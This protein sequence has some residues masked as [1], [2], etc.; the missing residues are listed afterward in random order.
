MK[1]IGMY[2]HIP[3]CKQKCKYCDF[4]SF[5]YD[6]NKVQEYFTYLLQEI[7]EKSNEIVLQK[8][9]E[10]NQVQKIKDL[11]EINT[12]YIGGGTPSIVSEKY[13][14]QILTQIRKN[15]K[16]ADNAEI[17]IEINPGTVNEEKLKKYLQIGINRISIGLQSANDKLL[18]MLGRIHTYEEFTEVYKLAREVGFKN[19]NVDL[20]IGLPTQKQ[21]DVKNTLKN[22]IEMNPEHIS[23]YSL[24]VEEN[25]QMYDLIEQGK[26]KL[27][28]EKT[29]R[30]MYWNVKNVL[31]E[32]G[33]IHYEISNFSKENKQSKHNL[34]CWN[35]EDY[36]GFGIAA[37]S[38]FNGIRYSNID[39]LKQY[40][41]NYKNDSSIYNVITHENQTKEDMMKEYMLLGLRKINGISIS[42]FKE[43]FTENPLYIYRNEL[44]KL[45]QKNLIEIDGN[46]IKLT[47]KGLDLANTVWI[48]FI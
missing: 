35:Q 8:D 36:L 15:Y 34:N 10:N 17:T 14:E 48:E 7:E 16:I 46:T 21:I 32:N 12:I 5:S 37:H 45:V 42:K 22:I 24:I 31:E 6:C 41:E 38:Y 3:F 2:I 20:M 4:I 26:L 9:S 47:N 19:I 33:Y 29:E 39:N 28:T 44:N 43:K 30:N 11:V 40:I 25:T 13:I 23:V 27:P 1:Q 18:E